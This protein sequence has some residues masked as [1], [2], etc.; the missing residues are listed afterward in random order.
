MRLVPIA[1]EVNF[2]P[3]EVLDFLVDTIKLPMNEN[4]TLALIKISGLS[5]FDLYRLALAVNEQFS[6]LK[7]SF[8]KD[9]LTI[10][11]ALIFMGTILMLEEEDWEFNENDRAIAKA[12]KTKLGMAKAI[13]TYKNDLETQ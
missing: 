12:L 2:T 4:D 5:F 9:T 11:F 6:F 7:A 10:D 13:G 3:E 8:P 1:D